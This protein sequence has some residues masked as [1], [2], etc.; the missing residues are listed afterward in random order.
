MNSPDSLTGPVNLGNPAEFSILQL[1]KKVIE[2]TN[3]ESDIIFAPLPSDDPTQR[4]PDISLAR[5][6]LGWNPGISLEKGLEKTIA[7]F[8]NLLTAGE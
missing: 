2:L 4:Q 8:G 3:S 5:K 6:S 1:A 7:Y